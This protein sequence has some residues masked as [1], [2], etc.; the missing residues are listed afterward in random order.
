ML[1]RRSLARLRKE[2]EP[3]PTGALARFLPAWQGVGS[4]TRGAE[5]LLRVV[6]QL[7]GAVV[8]ASA[9]ETTV[10]PSRVAGYSPALLDELTAAGEV[11]WCGVGS[12]PGGDGWLALAPADVADLLLPAASDLDPT[13]LH[14]AVLDRA[15]RRPGAVLPLAVRPGR[16]DRR[17]GAGR[18]GV[19]PGVGRSPHQRHAGAA[20]GRARLAG[21][22]AAPGRRR[23]P[24]RARYGAAGPAG[25]AVAHR[26]ARSPPAGGR[27]CRS[28]RPTR[29]GGRTRRR[30]CC[31]T[32]TACSPAGAVVAERS[33]GG[34]AAVYPV[35]RAAE[36]SGRARR[37]YFVESLGAAQ[38]ASPGAVDRLRTYAGRPPARH[39]RPWSRRAGAGGGAGGDRPGAAVRRGAAVAGAAVRQW[40]VRRAAGATGP[41]RKAGALVVLVDGHL[42]LYVERGGRT[43]LSWT[44]EPAR[45][46]AAADALALAVARGRPRPARRRARR[47][48]VRPRLVPALRR[49]R[50]GRLPAHPPRPPP[51]RLGSCDKVPLPA[52]PSRTIAGSSVRGVDVTLVDLEPGDPRLAAEVLPVLRELRP[53]LDEESFAAVYAEGHPQGL[54]FTAAYDGDRCVGV[55]GWRLVCSTH[56]I[57]KLYVDDLVTTAAAPLRRRRPRA[58]GRARAARQGRRL[59]RARPRLRRAPLRRAPLLLPGA[60][61]DHQ[62]PLR[63]GSRLA[64]ALPDSSPAVSVTTGVPPVRARSTSPLRSP[65]SSSAADPGS[66]RAGRHRAS[67][68]TGRID[69]CPRETP[70]GW[71][72]SA[73]TRRSPAGC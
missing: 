19:G 11:T 33:P 35:L 46:Q 47:R 13:E 65:S 49:P 15:G 66:R 37:G 3:V 58:A 25:D 7:A 30:R 56:T 67:R 5:G 48:G 64:T 10:L 32:G 1:R 21:R 2:V 62:P 72:A 18:G 16:L 12:L 34:F 57:R 8:P 24:T 44:E 54:R 36:E 14:R 31:S 20:A 45:L 71:R 59:H 17:R 4:R 38:F 61:G 51:A 40:T 69:R 55:A 70:S 42:T 41:G 6:E 23:A 68:G 9:L 26:P 22:A 27:G 39:R 50:V 29:P 52:A 63:Q 53:H 73:C 43:L 60:D 28:G